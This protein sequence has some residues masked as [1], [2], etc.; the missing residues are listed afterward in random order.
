[1]DYQTDT[2]KHRY[3]GIA[4]AALEMA[5]DNGGVSRDR[6]ESV[7]I[8]ELDRVLA[9][10]VELAFDLDAI[11]GWLETLSEDDLVIAVA[12]EQTEMARLLEAAPA[13]T[14]FLL[15]AIFDGS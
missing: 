15:N 13:G 14:D 3:P 8:D 9:G 1:M 12:G 6:P 5:Y 10:G 11:S 7:T 4:K 2:T